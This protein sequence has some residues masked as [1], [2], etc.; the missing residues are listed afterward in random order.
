MDRP[1][2]GGYGHTTVDYAVDSTDHGGVGVQTGSS[3]KLFTLLTALKKGVPFGFNAKYSSPV[4]L[5][6]YYNCQGQP[7]PSYV[8]LNNAEGNGS[9]VATLYNGTTGS[10]NVFYA[11]LER[12]VGLCSVVKTAVSL[13]VHRADGTSLLRGEG[14]KNSLY[15]QYSRR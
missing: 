15:Y 4:T 2:G 13:G 9:G 7:T 8:N 1:Y 12:K 5:S 10:I 11:E 6:G 14:K 3:S